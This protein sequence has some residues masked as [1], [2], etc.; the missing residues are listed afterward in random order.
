MTTNMQRKAGQYVCFSQGSKGGTSYYVCGTKGQGSK[1][2]QKEYICSWKF[3][4]TKIQLGKANKHISEDQ[5]KTLPMNHTLTLTLTHTLTL[6]L[7]APD[8]LNPQFQVT[9]DKGK[10]TV[11]G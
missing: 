11:L 3:W 1:A 6:T 8:F 4:I 10:G 5:D 2:R 7:N 9:R